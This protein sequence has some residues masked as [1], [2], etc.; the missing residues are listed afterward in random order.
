[1]VAS[2]KVGGGLGGILPQENWISG[3]LRSH[4]VQSVKQKC[5]VLKLLLLNI[6]I[7]FKRVCGLLKVWYSLINLLKISSQMP[8]PPKKKTPRANDDS[9]H[10]LALGG[11]GYYVISNINYYGF[12]KPMGVLESTE[13]L[14]HC[15]PYVYRL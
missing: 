12:S 15:L 7:A 6:I 10:A 8:P 13:H 14:H 5:I 1:M 2:G 9:A 11:G 4:L 3:S